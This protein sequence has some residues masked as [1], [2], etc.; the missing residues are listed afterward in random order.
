MLLLCVGQMDQ[1]ALIDGRLIW[2]V[3]PEHA[4]SDTLISCARWAFGLRWAF[5][6]DTN[7]QQLVERRGTGPPASQKCLPLKTSLEFL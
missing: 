3:D 7:Y 4:L 1:L 2:D 5:P 6:V